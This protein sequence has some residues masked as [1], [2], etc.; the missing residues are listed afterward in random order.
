MGS[1]SPPDI[2]KISDAGYVGEEAASNPSATSRAGFS[3]L[4]T[5]AEIRLHRCL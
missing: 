1:A 2:G 4:G 5:T 3:R